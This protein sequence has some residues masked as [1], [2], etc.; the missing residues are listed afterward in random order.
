MK[1]ELIRE[2]YNEKGWLRRVHHL[3]DN[4]QFERI[5][6]F[7]YHYPDGSLV[8]MLQKTVFKSNG[9]ERREIRSRERYVDELMVSKEDYGVNPEGKVFS[10]N[11][12]FEYEKDEEG[13]WMLSRLLE[14]G[15]LGLTVLREIEYW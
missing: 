13:N 7:H 15:K 14:K 6:S 3:D 9:G 12:T 5:E 10:K 8:M 2:D 11:I 1:S 4:L